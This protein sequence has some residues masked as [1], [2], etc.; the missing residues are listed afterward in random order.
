MTNCVP[1]EAEKSS[2]VQLSAETKNW[3]DNHKQDY[4]AV[5]LKYIKNLQ[6]ENAIVSNGKDGKVIEVP[7]TLD[8]NLKT[9]NG[10]ATLRNDSHRLVFVKDGQQNFKTYYIQIFAGD[11]NSSNID[12]ISTYYGVSNNFSGKIFKQ[13][14]KEN[15][16][17]SV[18]YKNGK[19][20]QLGAT[21][22]MREENLDCTFFGYWNG[23]GSFTPIRLLYCDG[24]GGEDP[25]IGGGVTTGGGGGANTTLSAVKIINNLT[26]KAKCLNDLLNRNG[27]SFVQNLF[28]KF[29]GTSKFDISISSV[30]ALPKTVD[31]V[32][33]YLN[34]RAL[35]PKGKLIEIEI[36][37]TEANKRAPLEV[38]RIILHEYI[39]A[40]IYRKLG[41]VLGTDKE[42]LDF[43]TT[44]EKYEGEH[45]S[46][47]AIL[48]VNS[49]KEALKQFHQSLFPND[50]SAYTAFY[51]EAPSDAFYE[52]LA[53]GGLRDSKVKAWNEL[54]AAQKA[55]IE[56]LASRVE[57]FSKTSPCGN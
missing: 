25:T 55:S 47:M 4:D 57:K 40:D 33:T 11:E 50:I 22:K 53:W 16:V 2:N 29:E 30:N 20:V 14:L 23:D 54:P 8:D 19:D 17:A 32:V 36:S 21:S 43:K 51:N 37:T 10:T 52:A 35:K 28:S 56:A 12:K 1:N 15:I 24:G 5:I 39:H 7:F 6:W 49:M 31:G 46:T 13:D 34:G 41:T 42:S 18:Q 45:H 44:Y 3:Y 38:A 48:Y 27:N 26:G 9:S